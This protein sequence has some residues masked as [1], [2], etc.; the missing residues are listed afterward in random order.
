MSPPEN[1]DGVALG[2]V[3]VS[4]MLEGIDR[5]EICKNKVS[6]L[7]SFIKKV[8]MKSRFDCFKA[9]VVFLLLY[10]ECDF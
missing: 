1:G 4:A 9:F 5:K 3:E 6:R 8:K 7:H 2:I 10:N